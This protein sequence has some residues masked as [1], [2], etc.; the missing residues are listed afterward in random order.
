[1]TDLLAVHNLQV[2]FR[3]ASGPMVVRGVSFSIQ[4]GETVGLVGE[5][6]SG[7]SLTAQAVMGLLPRAATLGPLSRI[8][9]HDID[10]CEAT[11]R[12]MQDLR[13]S[14]LAMVFQDPFSSLNPT[15]RLGEQVAEVLRM[16]KGLS[17]KDAAA[18]T[19]EMFE[20]VRLPDAKTK[21]FQY[22][23][24]IS[25]GQRQRVL[26]AMAFA[27]GPELL[28]ADEPTTALDVT[29]QAQI[30]ALMRE[31]AT[32]TRCGVLLITH[33][34]GVVAEICQ[35]VLVMY[36]GQIV[37]AG[38]VEQVL[39]APLHPYTQGL[40]RA[41][42]PLDGNRVD[43]LYALAG[44]PPDLSNRVNGCAFFERCPIG[45]QVPCTTDEPTLR[46]TISAG[47]S[48]RCHFAE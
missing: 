41:L 12:Q 29:V 42:P 8:L 6:G 43:R 20:L 1:M 39:T 32:N 11:E 45:R 28:I 30:L 17:A 9:F 5:S 19:V 40:L 15:M 47:Q 21:V 48:V 22:P 35:R 24:E 16:H 10:L 31:L 44:Q 25:G 27:C 37:E 14:K 4:P 46:P 7:K 13:G 18:R 36:A 23:H 34:L 3:G 26:L 38:S 33:D 2:G